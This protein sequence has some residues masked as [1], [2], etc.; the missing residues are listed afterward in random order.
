MIKKML[1]SLVIIL[2]VVSMVIY[3]HDKVS[4]IAGF[5]KIENFHKAYNIAQSTNLFK[6]YNYSKYSNSVLAKF[7]MFGIA[8]IV[9]QDFSLAEKY[10]FNAKESCDIYFLY[11]NAKKYYC[12]NNF[13]YLIYTVN[14]HTKEYNKKKCGYIQKKLQEIE[15]FGDKSFNKSIVY[16][17]PRFH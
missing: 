9:K 8:N 15:I 11:K 16:W 10:C 17:F 7:Y 3:V 6:G 5:M 1:L 14:N 2:F 12:D 4:P 13:K